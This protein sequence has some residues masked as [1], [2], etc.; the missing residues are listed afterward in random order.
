MSHVRYSQNG[1]TPL[2]LAAQEDHVNVAECLVKYGSSIDPQTK[3]RIHWLSSWLTLFLWSSNFLI[4]TVK[5][6]WSC[7]FILLA[8][9][10]CLLSK[11]WICCFVVRKAGYTPLHTACHFGQT[12]MVRYLLDH[13]ASVSS[14]TRVSG[15]SLLCQIITVFIRT[16]SHVCM[17][18]IQ[19]YPLRKPYYWPIQPVLFCH[20]NLIMK[21]INC[22]KSFPFTICKCE[23]EFY[24]LGYL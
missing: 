16:V 14:T 3:V 17:F 9:F 21:F 22:S 19:V 6:C 15:Y 7:I 4:F 5:N 10:I 13:G 23:R 1:L 2:H 24:E 18:F 8:F 20:N 12:N 11:N